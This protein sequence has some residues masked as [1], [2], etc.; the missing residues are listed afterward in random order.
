M[1]KIAYDRK[2]TRLYERRA[3]A[4]RKLAKRTHLADIQVRKQGKI[5]KVVHFPQHGGRVPAVRVAGKW[6]DQFGFQI[7]DLV[8][9]T[10]AKGR[11]IIDKRRP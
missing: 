11:L 6:L 8:Q 5:L 4:G 3:A 9:L 2:K 7:G 1:M 10:A